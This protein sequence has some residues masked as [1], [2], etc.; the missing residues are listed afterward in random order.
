MEILDADTPTLKAS[1]TSTDGEEGF[2]GNMD[3][4]VTF[5]VTDDNTLRIAYH[6]VSDK[7][8]IANFTNHAYF[9][10]NGYDSGDI[11]DTEVIMD[12]YAYTPTNEN[13][14]PTGEI[15]AVDGTPPLIC[16]P[17]RPGARSSTATIL[18][19]AHVAVWIITS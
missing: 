17:K 14:I 13:L 12:A 2:P 16:A 7:D 8:T 11:M 3:I 6:A 15:R 18:L 19:S 1:A 9:N 10:L 4:S 5:S